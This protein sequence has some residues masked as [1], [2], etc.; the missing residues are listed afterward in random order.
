MIM[1]KIKKFII[2]AIV[3]FSIILLFNNITLAVDLNKPCTPKTPENITTTTCTGTGCLAP[4]TCMCLPD[5]TNTNNTLCQIVGLAKEPVNC[6]TGNPQGIDGII[7]KVIGT[8][9]VIFSLLLALA[10]LYFVWG[11]V[12]YVTAG[13][14]EEKSAAGKKTMMYAIIALAVLVGVYGLILLVTGYLGLG[15]LVTLPFIQ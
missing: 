12:Q 10:V 8:M 14:D 13:G 9:G 3:L 7:C 4:K 2:G 5:P 15:E 6:A 11:V 1:K